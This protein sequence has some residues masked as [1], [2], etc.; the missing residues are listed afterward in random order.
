MACEITYEELALY[1][2]GETTE[3]RAREIRAHAARCK[4]CQ[5]RLKALSDV[6]G[7]LRSLP[8]TGPS[9]RVLLDVRRALSAELR[10]GGGPEIMTIDEVAGFL[11]V[12][13]EEL[14]RAAV[15]LPAFEIGG[16]IRVRRSKLIEWLEQRERYY[17]RTT[18]ESE[19]ARLLA[20]VFQEDDNER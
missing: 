18:I 16:V 17:T 9:P 5:R 2:A 12:S 20:G 11:R 7:A 15:D 6:D 19:A 8:R 3:E 4:D 1:S 14:E 13:R 10:G